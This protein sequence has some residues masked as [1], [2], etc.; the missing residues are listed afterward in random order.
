MAEKLQ[1][2][3]KKETLYSD[4]PA[5]LRRKNRD[6]ALSLIETE[7]YLRT[8]WCKDPKRNMRLECVGI[9]VDEVQAFACMD[10]SDRFTKVNSAVGRWVHFTRGTK[11]ELAAKVRAIAHQ[12]VTHEVDEWLCLEGERIVD[13]HPPEEWESGLLEGMK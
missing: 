10:V 2:V 12:L 4:K 9:S 6:T 7:A 3:I 11:A 1:F 13:P 8:F 5:I